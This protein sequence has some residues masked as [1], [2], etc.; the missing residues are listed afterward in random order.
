MGEKSKMNS[1][2]LI[3]MFVIVI[4]LGFC[5][6]GLDVAEALTYTVTNTATVGAGS[7]AQA[8]TDSSATPADDT[9][10]FNI[11]KSDPN[12]VTSEGVSYWL[13]TPVSAFPSP[14]AAFPTVEGTTIIDGTTQATFIGEETNP[15]GPEIMI[16]GEAAGNTHGFYFT[17]GGFDGAKIIGLIINNFDGVD[18]AGIAIS[19]RTHV[20]G[21]YI[22]TSATASSDVNSGNNNGI[23]ITNSNGCYLGST[24]AANRNIISG[25][26]DSGIQIWHGASANNYIVGNYIGTDRTGMTALPNTGSGVASLYGPDSTYI[27]DGTVNGRNIISGNDGNG[28]TIFDSEYNSILGNYIGL[29]QD[30]STVVTNEGYG[31]SITSSTIND[32]VWNSV[33]DGT[34]G[35]RNIISGNAQYGVRIGSR[36]TRLND[37]YIGTDAGGT[38]G[39]GNTSGGILMISLGFD[40]QDSTIEACVISGNNSNGIHF[41]EAGLKFE[42]NNYILGCK[43]G[44]VADGSSALANNGDGIHF[45]ANGQ[46][47]YIGDGTVAGRNIIS[48]NNGNGIYFTGGNTQ[49]NEVLAN[50]IGINAAGSATIPNSFSGIH[51]ED[52]SSSNSIGDGTTDGRNIV[53]GNLHKGILIMGTASSDNSI[54]GNYIGTDPT[55]AI[56]WGNTLA[57]VA[58]TDE[59]TSNTIGGTGGEGDRNVISGNDDV[60][61]LIEDSTSNEVYGN[62]IGLSANG[63]ADRGNG[64]TGIYVS[65]GAKYN[66]IGNGASNG[67]NVISG[68]AVNGIQITESG[69]TNNSI[70]GNFIGLNYLGSAEVQNDADGIFINNLAQSNIVGD[71][72]VGG[73]NVVSGNGQYGIHFNGS[74]YNNIN[75]NYIGTNTSG[76]LTTGLENT[77][78]P[79]NIYDNCTNIT[80]E[81]CSIKS[82]ANAIS[83]ANSVSD[84]TV[85]GN[86]V[87]G[88]GVGSGIVIG[89]AGDEVNS[90]IVGTCEVRDFATGLTAAILGGETLTVTHNT[91]VSNSNN[92]I[93]VV[94]G[95]VDIDNSIIANDVSGA[96]SGTGVNRQAGTVSV[97]Y[98]D[99]Y[100]NNDNYFGTVTKTATIHVDAKFVDV[101]AD[102]YNLSSNSFCIN[103]GTPEGSDMGAY[104]YDLSNPAARIISPNGSESWEAGSSQTI[105]WYASQEPVGIGNVNLLYSTD[106]GATYTSIVTGLSN[107][108]SYPWTL[109]IINSTTVKVSIEATDV[110]GGVAYDASDSNFTIYIPNFSGPVITIEA[111]NGGETWQG[112]SNQNI[113]FSYSDPDGIKANSLDIYYSVDGGAS[114]TNIITSGATVASP[115][116]WTIPSITTDEARIKIELQD[117]FNNYGTRES[118][119]N[120]EI[121]ST[122]P[123]VTTFSL[124]DGITGSGSYT[125]NP[126]VSVEAVASS[127]SNRMIISESSGFTGASWTAYA[128]NSTLSLSSTDGT[129]EVYFKVE[130]TASLESAVVT[131]SIILD[132]VAPSPP[133]LDSPSDNSTTTEGI[134]I[135]DWTEAADTTS[136]VASYEI[137]VDGTELATMSATSYTWP[138]SLEAGSHTWEVRAKDYAENWSAYQMTWTFT[139][140]SESPVDPT[141]PEITLSRAG[142]ALMNNDPI[143]K[144]PDFRVY[145]SDNLDI[146]YEGVSVLFA[147]STLTLTSIVSSSSTSADLSYQIGTD[148]A[149]GDYAIT[150]EAR[151]VAG[152]VATKEI[153]GLTVTDDIAIEGGVKVHP[154]QIQPSGGSGSGAGASSQAVTSSSS[155]KIA[156]LLTGD[157][158]T[159][160]LVISK[161]GVMHWVYRAA[162][163]AEGGKAGYNEVEYDGT[164]RI[165]GGYLPNG[166]YLVKVVAGNKI[167]GSGHLVVFE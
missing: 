115:Y 71:G 148:L 30:G 24:E 54:R 44:T 142:V 82:L 155:C 67:R 133:A 126:L 91:I 75:R 27:G 28:I 159:T 120:F 113:T 127:D 69:T 74:T 40:L 117:S 39:K 59:A 128:S 3:W 90:G 72:T 150:V 157:S 93:D 76:D 45:A 20:W 154:P 149:N 6:L 10:V 47:N 5:S 88:Q 21:C 167:V 43:I 50:Y 55:G 160:I 165:N 122:S 96:S 153:T 57:G 4:Y 79:V 106:S 42:R 1:K 164:S 95:V 48:G 53:S 92:G 135:F 7:L 118:A 41:T 29:A 104:Q 8:I 60:G 146:S 37:N 13:I 49:T 114:Y 16:S 144:Q 9:I 151:D 121:D 80:I 35:G 166:I 56:D 101:A 136:G 145:V 34:A 162:S 58:I 33:G 161:Y 65:N 32:A 97:S 134:V 61:I 99:I 68:N 78:I 124:K 110:T 156:Y 111:P 102:N 98:S 141:A 22:G 137:R 25:N 83:I 31:I 107:T 38:V 119:A 109:P 84:Y 66:S 125:N 14:L 138:S 123:E 2:F 70:L 19:G 15:L 17:S 143:V 85:K 132:T 139:V 100:G 140:S 105:T 130:D 112:G 26:N 108:G 103:S 147:G 64:L 36:Y 11:P 18:K 46:S 163:G 81:S 77:D 158:N 131:D 23:Y 73:I 86:T 94:S 63:L 52:G 51:I 129:K 87:V 89:A 12:F 152:N 116:S 62:Y